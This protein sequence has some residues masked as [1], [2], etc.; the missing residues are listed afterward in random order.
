MNRD[1][2]LKSIPWFSIGIIL[3]RAK[4]IILT[5]IVLQ[6]GV[7]SVAIFYLSIHLVNE[8]SI[9]LNRLISSSYNH[10]LR[11]EKFMIEN[12]K[13]NNLIT[14]YIQTSV[15][16]GIIG[17]ILVFFLAFPISLLLNNSIF[18]PSLEMLSVSLIFMVILHANM[19]IL[20]LLKKFKEVVLFQ[21]FIEAIL[22][23][24]GTYI[25]ISY[26][27]ANLQTVIIWQGISF[28]FSMLVSY[29][30]LLTLVPKFHFVFR[31]FPM[32]LK[33]S[34]ISFDN[35]IFILLLRLADLFII[36]YFLG[37]RNLGLY[38]AFLVIPHLIYQVG[39]G[40]CS[41]FI[42]TAASFYEDRNRLIHFS[43]KVTQL[44]V[45]LLTFGLVILFVYP[46]ESLR[47]FFIHAKINYF[48]LG[49]LSL[50]YFLR[51][52]GWMGGQILIV[53]KKVTENVSVNIVIP[54]I[55]IPLLLVITPR[56]GLVGVALIALGLSIADALLKMYFTYK[57]AKV[58]Y[59]SWQ[60]MKIMLVGVLIFLFSKYVYVSSFFIFLLYFPCAFI[61]LLLLV[62]GI[63]RRDLLLA[64]GTLFVILVTKMPKS[65]DF[66]E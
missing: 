66:Q 41:M 65:Q 22:I 45:I 27:K 13:R 1:V 54:L 16:F 9:F 64:K 10:Y 20:S 43:Q 19:K 24:V 8:L 62:G 35:G 51:V 32:G 17:G 42:H 6:L 38:F 34:S 25:S 29:L 60:S 3:N 30:L 47:L 28:F 63:D 40:L 44:I 23:L 5:G 18:V 7:L 21:N 48:I 12:K 11:D 55:G 57:K 49:I 37:V 56:Y 36:G 59:V 2:F 33:I 58:F 61:I 14:S 52:L 4:Y 26:F 46:Q 50:G 39:T 31:L 15:L 53:T